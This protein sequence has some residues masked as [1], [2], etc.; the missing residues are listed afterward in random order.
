MSRSSGGSA[1]SAL[2]LLPGPGVCLVPAGEEETPIP[3][4]IPF[5]GALRDHSAL[6][7]RS[8]RH[9][10][11]GPRLR[12][13]LRRHARRARPKMFVLVMLFALLMPPHELIS[14]AKRVVQSVHH[15]LRRVAD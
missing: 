11:S 1:G 3:Y 12:L 6:L 8:W 4:P 10:G 15:L 5:G 7:W 14:P 2:A 13:R 9:A